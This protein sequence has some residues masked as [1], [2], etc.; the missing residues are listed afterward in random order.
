LLGTVPASPERR[1]EELRGRVVAVTGAAGF[2]GANLVAGLHAIGARVVAIVRPGSDARR[3]RGLD[4]HVRISP[5][6]V[7]DRERLATA[8][9]GVDTI[10]H[11]AA[12]GVDPREQDTSTLI[13]TNVI[14]PLGVVDAAADL[15]VRRLVLFGS[16]FEYGRGRNVAEHQASAPLTDYGASKAAGVLVAR[17]HARRR[18]VEFV[19]LRPFTV[20][21]PLEADRRLVPY[22]IGCAL[23]GRPLELSTGDQARDFVHVGDVVEACLAAATASDIDGEVFNVCTGTAT[24]VREL[25]ATVLR[26]TGSRSHATFGALEYRAAD[27]EI[28]TGDPRRAATKLGWRATTSLE[29]GLARTIE[30]YVA[31]TAGAERAA[32]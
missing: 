6:D 3:L 7:R 18:G 2:I 17:T 20:Y 11:L 9:V 29:A 19:C 24:T 25:V 12:A 4:T 23:E 28:L 21:G 15:G 30:R 16:C 32:R 14:G 31:S 1:V 5:V 8:L 13:D 27:V 22:A 26:L 10:F